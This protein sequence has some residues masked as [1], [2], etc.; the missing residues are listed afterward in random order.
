MDDLYRLEKPWWLP[1][2]ESVLRMFST[3]ANLLLLL[4]IL[5]DKPAPAAFQI[6]LLFLPAN[7]M[8]AFSL[9]FHSPRLVPPVLHG[10]FWAAF[11]FW[12]LTA[13]R[14]GMLF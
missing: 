14:D 3:L 5:P 4:Q 9:N 12:L 11:C 8:V 10:F 6:L 1:G 2:A 13:H 7:L